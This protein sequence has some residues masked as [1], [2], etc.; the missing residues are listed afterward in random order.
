MKAKKTDRRTIYTRNI[1]KDTLLELL[2]TKKFE[3]ITITE[4]CKIAE[5]NRGTFYLHYYDLFDVLDEI[6]NDFIQD[7]PCVLEHLFPENNTDYLECNYPFCQKIHDNK[8]YTTIFFDDYLTSYIIDKIS[9]YSKDK[10]IAKLRE[11]S[12]LT[13]RQAEALFYFQINGCLAVNKIIHHNK[14][15]DQDEIRKII[16]EFIRNGLKKYLSD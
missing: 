12:S 13:V 9:S 11:K 2:Q 6:F 1:I 8:K 10:F 5:I 14:Y 7:T 16:D 3:K 15:K 4:L